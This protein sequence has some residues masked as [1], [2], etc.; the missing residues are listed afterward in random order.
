MFTETQKETI[1]RLKELNHPWKDIAETVN[2]KVGTVRQF[3]KRWQ[4]VKDLP[5]KPIISKSIIKGRLLLVFKQVMKENPKLSYRAIPAAV[6]ARMSPGVYIPS[7]TTFQSF[8]AKNDI[9]SI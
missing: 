3:Y 8:L 2:A 7:A 5:P 9:E 1:K 4:K 6:K